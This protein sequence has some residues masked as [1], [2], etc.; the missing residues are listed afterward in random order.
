MPALERRP[1]QLLLAVLLSLAL[2]MPLSCKSSETPS[3]FWN[4][5]IID[6]DVVGLG[7]GLTLH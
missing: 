5:Q 2:S 3:L 1:R 7:Y 6:T 4:L